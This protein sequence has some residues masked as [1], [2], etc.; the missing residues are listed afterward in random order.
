MPR[1]ERPFRLGFLIH[2]V[3]RL[4]RTVV[5]KALRP[6]GVTRSQWWV[7][8]NLSRHNGGGMMQTELSKVMDVGKVTLG[9]L[10][11]RLEASGYVQR[12]PEPG[13][14]RA[15]RVV[16]TPKGI[17]L[18]GQIQKVGKVVNAQIMTGISA[19]DILRAENLLHKMKQQLIAMDAVP[20]G[21]NSADDE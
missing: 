14:R 19:A 8:A 7:L 17:K 12:Q 3:S 5:D 11:D 21:S 15:K 6:L 16:M 20:G 10:I 4:R 18:L 1:N 2:D 9:G 13:D